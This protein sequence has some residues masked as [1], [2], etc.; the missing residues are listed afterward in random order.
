MDAHRRRVL[1]L[2]EQG[3]WDDVL[4]LVALD[5][6]LA[7][8]QDD[9]GMLP[10]HWACT[11]PSVALETIKALLAA[12]PEACQLENLSG[13]A[14]LHVAIASKMTG[15]AINALLQ[16]YPEAAFMK[17]GSGRYPIELAM[18]NNLP[19]FTIDLIRKA[20]ARAVQS[21]STA[22]VTRSVSFDNPSCM[23]SSASDA[24]NDT[25]N[26]TDAD[27]STPP[28]STATATTAEFVKA[29][30]IG[31]LMASRQAS[32][33][34]RL[35]DAQTRSSATA[36]SL[37]RSASASPIGPIESTEISVH[38]KALLVQ[39]QQL[40][41][42]I[43]SNNKASSG[44][45]STYRSSLSSSSSGSRHGERSRS[46]SASAAANVGSTVLWNPSDKLGFV[47]EPVVKASD[48]GARIKKFG[49]RSSVLGVET[50]SVGD[51]LVSING[52]SVTA[53]SFASITRFLKHAK[54]TCKLC[55]VK[56]ECSGGIDDRNQSASRSTSRSQ[57]L[58]VGYVRS[59]TTSSSSSSVY[60]T[61]SGASLHRMHSTSSSAINNNYQQ[62]LVHP[63]A[64]QDTA[65][66]YA[67]VAELLD[68][69]LKKVA[70]V[71][72][73]V[74]LSSAMSFCA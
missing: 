64:D 13:M 1:E 12:F 29:R 33:Y 73:T 60:S 67:K 50:L 41:V 45:D 49:S 57:S 22:A 14:P 8:A 59:D 74:R 39:L 6:A 27:A 71:E 9:F 54:V 51:V 32:E 4:E 58:P 69:T 26:D 72:E 48:T 3:E 35:L 53:S 42:D 44:S 66:L 28:H 30:S 11:E 20:G 19:K 21:S 7:K 34:A 18:D 15:L 24:G 25:G 2:A 47:M 65:M 63:T 40:S 10:L 5:P 31:S 17:D 43:R 61:M 70:A 68:T 46:Q 62:Q 23:A 55:F 52:T 37:S 38:L 56:S 36:G 16:T